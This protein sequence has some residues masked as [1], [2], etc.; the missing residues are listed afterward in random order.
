M[1]LASAPTLRPLGTLPTG[2]MRSLPRGRAVTRDGV[3]EAHSLGPTVGGL[4]GSGVPTLDEITSDEPGFSFRSSSQTPPGG[5]SLPVPA[6]TRGPGRYRRSIRTPST[7]RGLGFDRDSDPVVSDTIGTTGYPRGEPDA[8]NPRSSHRVD[9]PPDITWFLQERTVCELA[10]EVVRSRIVLGRNRWSKRPVSWARSRR[11][12]IGKA[13]RVS[14]HGSRVPV[15]PS[16]RTFPGSVARS[17]RPGSRARGSRCTGHDRGI[18]VGRPR[19]SPVRRA[20]Q[21]SPSRSS[22]CD[23]PIAAEPPSTRRAGL[24]RIARRR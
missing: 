15:T 9:P 7:R 5:P 18:P 20:P 6:R 13:R 8:R 16:S 23:L 2:P 3:S 12:R 19:D 10:L 14:R 4:H 22:R 11:S 24:R 1:I 17:S 21:S